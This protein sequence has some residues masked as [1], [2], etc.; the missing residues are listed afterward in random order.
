MEYEGCHTASAGPSGLGAPLSRGTAGRHALWIKF[1]RRNIYS[2]RSN[3]RFRRSDPSACQNFFCFH[4][5][6]HRLCTSYARYCTGYP[7]P[8]AHAGFEAGLLAAS[9]AGYLFFGPK[10]AYARAIWCCWTE[11]LIRQEQFV[12][13][14]LWIVGITPA[15]SHAKAGRAGLSEPTGRP[16]QVA[17]RGFSPRRLSRMDRRRALMFGGVHNGGRQLCL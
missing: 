8:L 2:T 5:F 4:R 12:V 14:N 11:S 17:E 9:V 1:H 13:E 16:G 10:A 6:P 3:G 15:D 7:H